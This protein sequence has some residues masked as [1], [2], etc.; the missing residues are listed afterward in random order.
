MP[1]RGRRLKPRRTWTLNTTERATSKAERGGK[2]VS[3]T[4]TRGPI[5]VA[6]WIADERRMRPN[7]EAVGA[8]LDRSSLEMSDRPSDTLPELLLR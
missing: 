3:R 4:R 5:G 6:V 7:G 8:S 2:A 1:H